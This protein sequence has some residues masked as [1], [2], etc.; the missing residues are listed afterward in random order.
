MWLRYN[1][2]NNGL[3][4]FDGRSIFSPCLKERTGFPGPGHPSELAA[5]KYSYLAHYTC[6]Q[7]LV[8]LVTFSL[9]Y[10]SKWSLDP[11]A[12]PGC[13]CPCTRGL[14]METF[15]GRRQLK[16]EVTSWFV[17]YCACSCSPHC[18]RASVG[19]VKLVCLALWRERECLTFISI[20]FVAFSK[21]NFADYRS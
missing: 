13:F 16:P 6:A 18:R 1:L 2:F 4:Y 11:I 9:T 8:Q 19:D 15:S 10:S 5:L 12:A 21:Q 7:S 17:Q 20:R 14:K 3:C